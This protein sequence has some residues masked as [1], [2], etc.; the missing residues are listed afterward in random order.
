ME[1]NLGWQIYRESESSR[2]TTSNVIFWLFC[3]SRLVGIHPQ[4][5]VPAEVADVMSEN[6]VG[7]YIIHPNSLLFFNSSSYWYM[8]ILS[9]LP[10][11]WRG[12]SWTTQQHP[13]FRG[14]HEVL[15]PGATLLERRQKLFI[16]K[17]TPSQAPILAQSD[18]H[19][20]PEWN[21][22]PK[23]PAGLSICSALL[24]LC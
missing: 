16:L 13:S 19:A 8:W 4:T 1:A 5:K 12:T 2:E 18:E 22:P 11:Q 17:Y 21:M 10:A 20:S 14:G 23:S 24:V 3:I 6:L 7:F 15:K 9:A